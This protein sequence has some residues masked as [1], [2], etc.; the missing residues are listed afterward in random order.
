M[1][2]TL[3][4]GFLLLGGAGAAGMLPIHYNTL[5]LGL[6]LLGL[7]WNLVYVGAGAL[8]AQSVRAQSRHRWQGINDTLIA[9]CA[10]LGALSPAP[11]LAGLG[12]EVTNAIVVPVCLTGLV[13]VWK[14]LSTN[15][16]CSEQTMVATIPIEPSPGKHPVG[17]VP[18]PPAHT[19]Y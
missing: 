9:A 14:I 10:T 19:T 4:T 13:L 12:W 15:G 7:G 8:L 2:S 11:L 1:R 6:L 5:V 18:A 3:A 16:A 17:A